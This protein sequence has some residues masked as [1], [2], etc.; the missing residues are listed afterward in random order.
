MTRT[1]LER[2]VERHGWYFAGGV[3]GRLRWG[4]GGVLVFA[5]LGDVLRGDLWAVSVFLLGVYAPFAHL[6]REPAGS[7]PPQPLD[8]PGAPRGLR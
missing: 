6:R 5:G 4:V 8:V 3:P 2:F 1:R 7:R